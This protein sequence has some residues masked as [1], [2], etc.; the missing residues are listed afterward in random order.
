MT[1]HDHLRLLVIDAYDLPSR[2]ALDDH[3]VLR[4]GDAYRQLLQHL[5][6]GAH[7]DI[8]WCANA[9]PLQGV[10]ALTSYHGVVWTG[11][12]LSVYD[13]N[14][15]IPRQIDLVRA[16]MAAN[17]PAFGSCYAAQIATVANGGQVQANPLGREFGVGR[18]IRLTADG[19]NHPLYRDKG[20]VF[21]AFT[22]HGDHIT[23]LPDGATVLATNAF[24]PIQALTIEPPT[25]GSFWAVQ[26]HPEF[27][28]D[29]MARLSRLRAE[30]LITQ[31]LFEDTAQ[32]ERYASAME[33]LQQNPSHTA[34]SFA[35]GVDQDVLNPARR[36]QEVLNW[37]R[38]KVAQQ[39]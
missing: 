34:L 22:C 24:S 8:A 2:T 38:H 10:D 15:V 37:F 4:G 1:R 35:Y 25:G 6:P 19:Q 13:D 31:G 3:G 29:Y 20:P 26:Y 32:V 30:R 21:D 16:T 28:A 7:V 18:K 27:D 33:T 17:I 23:A 11:S 9:D 39:T 5:A 36:T 12:S 14:P